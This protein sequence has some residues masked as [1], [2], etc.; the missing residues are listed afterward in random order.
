MNSIQRLG[1]RRT[2]A[3]LLSACLL[4]AAP[5]HADEAPSGATTSGRPFVHPLFTDNMVVQRDLRVPVWGWAEPG[6]KVA[7]RFDDQDATTRADARGKWLATLGP[8]RAGGPFVLR[9]EGPQTVTLTNVLVGDVWICSGQSNMEMGIGGVNDASTEIARADFPRIRLFTVPKRIAPTTQETVADGRWEV[10]TPTTVA[11]GGWGG[12]SAVGYFFGRDLHRDL[13]VPI[14]LIHTSW[15][16]TVAEAWTS[17]EALQSMEDFRPALT[18]LKQMTE[19]EGKEGMTFER[20]MS[21]WYT[22]ND[23][24][25][26]SVAGWAAPNFA[27]A[28]WQTMVLPQNWEPAGLPDFDGVVWFRKELDLAAGWAGREATLHLGP[29][30]DRDVTWVNGVKVGGT[31]D[32][33]AARDYRVPAGVLM[34]GRNVIVV[35][36]LDTGG[37]GGLFGQPEQMRLELAGE[38]DPG[39]VILAGRWQYRDSVSLAK[40]T[41]VP[42]AL[43]NNPNVVSVLY[44]GMIAPLVPFAVKGAI[45]YQGESNAGRGRQYRTLLPELI[46]DWRSRFGVGDFP[47]LIVQLANFM[48][49]K[50]EPVESAWAELREAQLLTS[51]QVR[52]TGLAVAID[53]GDAADIHPKN[54]QEVG[55]RLAL[56]AE[57]IAYGK[58]LEYSGPVYRSM[59][60]EDNRIRLRFDH[61]GGG[62][63]AQ[64]GPPLKGF[65]VAGADGNFVWAEALIEGDTVVV[66]N[67][68]IKEPVA[69]R[70]GWAEN[71]V[72]NLYNRAGLP[73]SPFRTNPGH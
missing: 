4:P 27:A 24:G 55:R 2:L 13:D 72:C 51:Q 66:T 18:Q 60:R 10:C 1:I 28:D 29:I 62:L 16:G 12:F 64:G 71:P 54:K 31:D 19:H 47:F 48:E 7:L 46:G 11:A 22:R 23:P 32:W 30:D 14:G 45:W 57:A 6:Q 44:N 49:T 50:S 42:Q 15:G 37:G 5:G 40:A 65:A 70:Y 17:A 8:F 67:P 52:K 59:D 56:A 9:I 38:A 34:A 3:I 36:V 33:L 39:P 20:L 26:A 43:E 68:Q 63:V 25:S 58:L 69:V 53:I 41:P 35:R 73:A 61:V 21:D